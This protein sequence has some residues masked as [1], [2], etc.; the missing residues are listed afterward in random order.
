VVD[1]HPKLDHFLT[2][3][4]PVFIFGGG[5]IPDGRRSAPSQPENPTP[6][7]IFKEH[8][9]TDIG[10][11]AKSVSYNYRFLLIFTGQSL[12]LRGSSAQR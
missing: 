2:F 3:F 1:S 11:A 4:L 8:M 6:L 9:L 7:Q 5:K 10:G 12:F